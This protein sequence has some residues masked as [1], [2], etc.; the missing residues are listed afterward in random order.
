MRK[1]KLIISENQVIG[2][3]KFMEIYLGVPYNGD[4]KLTHYEMEEYLIEKG[5][6]LPVRVS[7]KNVNMTKI[8]N[9]TYVVVREESKKKKRGRKIVYENPM[10]LSFGK[11]LNEL[12]EKGDYNKLKEV[13][14]KILDKDFNLEENYFG[15]IVEKVE[16]P[17]EVEVTVKIN[18]QKVHKKD[19][20]ISAKGRRY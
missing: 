2:I 1:D 9:G 12:Q 11:L 18:R 4:E 19:F 15:D 20:K 3:K 17:I 8:N 6:P 10:T 5:E 16:E 7:L 13:R 14:A